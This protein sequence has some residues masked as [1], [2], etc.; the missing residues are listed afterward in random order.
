MDPL[1]RTPSV[2]ACNLT[3][4]P[5]FDGLARWRRLC[6]LSGPMVASLTWN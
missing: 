1:V 5:L 6:I 3:D 2:G 4:H